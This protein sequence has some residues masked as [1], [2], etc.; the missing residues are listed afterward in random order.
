[1]RKIQKFFKQNAFII[2]A[3]KASLFGLDRTI[4]LLRSKKIF[5]FVTLGL[6]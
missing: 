3:I 1:M 5:M 6:D 2:E 4:D